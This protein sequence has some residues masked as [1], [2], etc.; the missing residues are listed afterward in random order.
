MRSRATVVLIVLSAL[1][2]SSCGRDWARITAAYA[3]TTDARSV[4][5]QLDVCNPPQAQIDATE[6][7][8]TD[9]EIHVRL[10]IPYP[11]GD[12]DACATSIEIDLERPVGDR[13]VID[14]RNGWTVIVES[15]T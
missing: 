2:L 6:V 8:E 13:R 5:L 7:E 4:R 1:A 15:G 12:A 11:T 3:P 10:H 14:V 9:E